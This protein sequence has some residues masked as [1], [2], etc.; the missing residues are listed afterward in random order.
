MSRLRKPGWHIL[1][2]G[3]D[4]KIAV[5]EVEKLFYPSLA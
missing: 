3:C 2:G 1:A 5:C 4:Y